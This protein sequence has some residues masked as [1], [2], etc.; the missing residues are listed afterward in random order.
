MAE[1]RFCY[2]CRHSLY[3]ENKGRVPNR[4]RVCLYCEV[5]HKFIA[6]DNQSS[7]LCFDPE[8]KNNPAYHLAYK[9]T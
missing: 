8:D 1:T 6:K 9:H 5:K 2:G 7:P 3:V 4:H